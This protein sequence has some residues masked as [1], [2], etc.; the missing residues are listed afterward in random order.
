VGG[1]GEEENNNKKF[2]TRQGNEGRKE[3][4]NVQNHERF[5]V[6]IRVL[7]DIK[8]MWDITPYQLVNSYGNFKGLYHLH[9]EGQAVL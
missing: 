8:D 6:L 2:I 3:Y 4:H 5:E 9:L 7:L 1:R